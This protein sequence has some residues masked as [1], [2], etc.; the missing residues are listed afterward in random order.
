MVLLKNNGILPLHSNIGTVHLCGPFAD[1]VDA[2]LGTWVFPGTEAPGAGTSPASALAERLGAESLVV[3]DGRFPDLTA[4]RADGADL[5]IAIVGE[6]PSSSGED[7]CLPNAELPVGQFELLRQLAMLGKP[8]VVVVVTARPLEF[9]RYS[10][11]RRRAARLAPGA[12]AGPA[13]ADVLLGDRR[14]RDDCR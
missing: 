13:L 7:R 10:T 4:R 5:T 14:R 12:E 11:G 3:S 2:L 8:L 6:H 9:R 1:D